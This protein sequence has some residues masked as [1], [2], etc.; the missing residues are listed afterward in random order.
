MPYI[1][2]FM[3]PYIIQGFMYMGLYIPIQGIP[4]PNLLMA[5]ADPS[6]G[7][8]SIVNN[9]VNVTEARYFPARQCKL[10]T[11]AGNDAKKIV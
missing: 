8:P 2:G 6:E 9:T 11:V 4:K 10:T 1:H 3:P 7:S 5:K